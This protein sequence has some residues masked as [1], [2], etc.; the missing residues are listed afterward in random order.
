MASRL[1]RG[2]VVEIPERWLHNITTR[3]TIKER[4][5]LA[6]EVRLARKKRLRVQR[7]F[8]Y[9]QQLLD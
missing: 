7:D 6:V 3:G 5:E 4:K 8:D 1:R 9:Q 2:K